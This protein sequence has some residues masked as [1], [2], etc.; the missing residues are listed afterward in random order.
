M[1]VL[2]SH[3][4]GKNAE[5]RQLITDDFILRVSS[6]QI[7]ESSLNLSTTDRDGRTSLQSPPPVFFIFK[8]DWISQFSLACLFSHF[9]MDLFIFYVPVFFLHCTTCVTEVR[10]GRQILWSWRFEWLWTTMWV[11]TPHPNPLQAQALLTTLPISL[12]PPVLFLI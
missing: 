4:F 2:K 7:P 3:D 6:G 10:R 5:P 9:R 12:A 8:L 11:L 1:W